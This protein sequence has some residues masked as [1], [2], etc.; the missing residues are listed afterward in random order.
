MCR[1][2]ERA[3]VR[4]VAGVVEMH[5]SCVKQEHKDKMTLHCQCRFRTGAL[6]PRAHQVLATAVVKK[7]SPALPCSDDFVE[8]GNLFSAVG[9]MRPPRCLVHVRGG[10]GPRDA[11]PSCA[12]ATTVSINK[13]SSH[14]SPSLHAS[15]PEPHRSPSL[16]SI[17]SSFLPLN[18]RS[19]LASRMLP[20]SWIGYARRLMPQVCAAFDS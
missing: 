8:A 12:T 7:S 16:S 4:Q 20:M 10:L 6:G 9:T 3:T 11:L 2:G 17:P 18:L 5:P 13:H 19:C 14:A 1:Q 15:S